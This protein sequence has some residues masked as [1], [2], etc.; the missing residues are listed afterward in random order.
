MLR[1]GLLASERE[2]ECGLS[3]Q[4]LSNDCSLQN[5]IRNYSTLW[6][7]SEARSH[8]VALTVLEQQTKLVS[9]FQRST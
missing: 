1:I 8:R 7:M 6:V 3:F 2:H 5:A 4:L 9:N